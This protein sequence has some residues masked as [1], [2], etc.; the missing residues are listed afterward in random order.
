[1]WENEEKTSFTVLGGGFGIEIL[2]H[3]LASEC[4]GGGEEGRVRTVTSHLIY[5]LLLRSDTKYK[6]WSRKTELASLYL[7]WSRRTSLKFYGCSE[8]YLN[9]LFVTLKLHS[10]MIYHGAETEGFVLS[11]LGPQLRGPRFRRGDAC[12]WPLSVT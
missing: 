10:G 8:S 6:G 12:P 11:L 5:H 3:W 9:H 2:S 7:L 1:M 4:G